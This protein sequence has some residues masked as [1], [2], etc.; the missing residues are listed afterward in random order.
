[1]VETAESVKSALSPKV[2]ETLYF[3]DSTIAMC[4]CH[5]VTKRMRMYTLFRVAEIR[6]HILG[7]T[8]PEGNIPLPLYHIDGKLN[9]ADLITKRHNIMP[10]DLNDESL[11]QK[12]YDWMTLPI[13]EMPITTYQNLKL[14]EHQESVVDEECFKEA[15]MSQDIEEQKTTNNEPNHRTHLLCT[16]FSAHYMQTV[17]SASNVQPFIDLIKHGWKKSLDILSKIVQFVLLL[18]HSYHI[19]KGIVRDTNCKYCFNTQNS[20]TSGETPKLY[21]EEAK[22]YLFK[23]ESDKLK[24]VLPSKKLKSF[25]LKDGIYYYESRLTEEVCKEDIDYH[26]FFDSYGQL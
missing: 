1:M 5:S 17:H 3:T 22:S 25:I 19:T 2:S 26:I 11:W 13:E 9:V 23:I 16:H 8:N 14:S 21:V 6:K 24:S 15:I 18:K 12:G 10:K 7:T 4:W 20:L